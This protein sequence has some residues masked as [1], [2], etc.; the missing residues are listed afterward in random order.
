M[1]FQ[2]KKELRLHKRNRCPYEECGKKFCSH[3][4]A[5]VHEQVHEDDIHLSAPAKVVLCH[6]SGH[7][8]GLSI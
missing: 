1:S 4:Y 7:R 5:I 3:R 8:L 2:T 6:S